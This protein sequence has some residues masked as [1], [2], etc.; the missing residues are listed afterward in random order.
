[1]YEVMFIIQP[2]LEAEEYETILEDLNQLITKLKGDVVR[3]VDW[4]RRKLAYEI[5]KLREGHYYLIYFKGESA[6]ITELEHYFRV[7]DEVMRNMIIK[8]DED[9]IDLSK[10]GEEAQSAAIESSAESN[11]GSDKEKEAVVAEVSE[12][13]E[14]AVVI[15]AIDATAE[16]RTAE[17][18]EVIPAEESDSDIKQPKSVSDSEP[19]TEVEPE[20]KDDSEKGDAS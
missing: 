16:A 13:A 1:M 19:V 6:I 4:K 14:A 10:L 3:V 2:D 8:V 12:T 15:E 20:I 7:S 18:E 17:N 11:A 9:S 5:N